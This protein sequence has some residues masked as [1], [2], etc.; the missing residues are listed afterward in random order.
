MMKTMNHMNNVHAKRQHVCWL[1]VEQYE[2]IRSSSS[3]GNVDTEKHKASGAV[4]KD[5][6]ENDGPWV[7]SAS[8]NMSR[9]YGI[10]WDPV[11][12]PDKNWQFWII[13]GGLPEVVDPKKAHGFGTWILLMYGSL[14]P[15]M[16]YVGTS[17]SLRGLRCSAPHLLQIH[18]SFSS[19]SFSQK[20]SGTKSVHLFVLGLFRIV[21]ET[22][23]SL[24]GSIVLYRA[25][26]EMQSS[27]AMWGYPRDLAGRGGGVA[28]MPAMGRGDGRTTGTLWRAG[29][30]RG[31][32]C[33]YGN[34]RWP[35]MVC[36]CNL[37]NHFLNERKYPVISKKK[38]WNNEFTIF[39]VGF[40]CSILLGAPFG[41]SCWNRR[42]GDSKRKWL[43]CSARRWWR[44]LTWPF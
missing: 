42:Q 18:Y 20:H 37:L 3:T 30:K 29:S 2:S 38:D 19:L 1:L 7:I 31:K 13:L 34:P 27:I 24:R 26:L 36:I 40:H 9:Q 5:A 22:N 17:T 23:H 11:L 10:Q 44:C 39:Y 12:Q 35:Q 14:L 8:K 33:G 6:T 43:R 41:C 32:R 15:C 21:L 25:D 28:A 4:G 16:L